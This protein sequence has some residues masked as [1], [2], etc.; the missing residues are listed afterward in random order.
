MKRTVP[1]AAGLMN[2]GWA[3]ARQVADDAQTV[4]LRP[5]SPADGIREFLALAAL[6]EQLAPAAPGRDDH[7]AALMATAAA[8]RRMGAA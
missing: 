6:A 8:F 5:M 3:A 1:A 2:K 4:R 7:V